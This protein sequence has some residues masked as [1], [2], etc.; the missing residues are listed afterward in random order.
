MAQPAPKARSTSSGTSAQPES[1]E[2]G[3]QPRVGRQLAK[4]G[5]QVRLVHRVLH[6]FSDYRLLHGHPCKDSPVENFG[7]GSYLLTLHTAGSLYTCATAWAWV[8][9][10]TECCPPRYG[11]TRIR[12]PFPPTKI[13]EPVR[14]LYSPRRSAQPQYA[15]RTESTHN[16]RHR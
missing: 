16:F 6:R 14:E 11:R 7:T 15:R 8:R 9:V 10:S 2:G 1:L 4:I 13:H 3:T 12:G 5:N